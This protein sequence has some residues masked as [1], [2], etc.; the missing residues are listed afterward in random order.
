MGSVLYY[1]EQR[2]HEELDN[3]RP[4]DVYL[5]RDKFPR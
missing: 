2:Y 5:G 4:I 1:N 3:L